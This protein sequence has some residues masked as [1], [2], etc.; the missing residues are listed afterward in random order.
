MKYIL[1]VI[2]LVIVSLAQAQKD[3]VELYATDTIYTKADVLPSY[4]NGDADWNKYLKK[5]LKYPKKAWW[6]QIEGEVLVEFVVRYDGIITDVK[7]LTYAENWG[8]EQEAV[9]VIKESG[10]W[11]AAVL[12]GR[13]VSYYARLTIPFRL[14][15]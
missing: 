15:Y 9:R 6:E 4:K 2:L 1:S 10:K 5:N 8:F 7:N 14:K 13:K 11:N 12:R 3:K